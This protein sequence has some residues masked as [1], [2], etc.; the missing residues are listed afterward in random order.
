MS[1]QPIKNTNCT[2]SSQEL[3]RYSRHLSLPEIGVNGQEKLKN[4]SV[5]CIGCGGLGSP[6]LVY[7]AAAGIGRIGIIDPDLVEES[8]LQRQIIHKTESIGKAKVNS[9]RSSIKALNPFCSVETFQACLTKSNALEIIKQFDIICDCSDNFPSRYLINDSCVILEK[10]H[11]YGAISKFEGQA[12][13]FNIDQDSPNFRDLVPT[14]PP[15]NLLPSCSEAGVMGILPGIIGIIQA[16]ETIKIITGIGTSLSGRLL[17][18]NALDMKFKE[19]NLKKESNREK[20]KNLIDY[21]TFCSEKMPDFKAIN[22]SPKKL[23]DLMEKDPENTILLDVRNEEEYLINSIPGSILIP[24]VNIQN[25]DAIKRIEEL[26]KNK[27]LY[28]HCKTGQRSLEAIYILQKYGI[29][30]INIEGGINSW[31]QIKYL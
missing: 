4:S 12:S 5:L 21:E 23:N 11:I 3:K 9:A 26:S 25:G 6:L 22:I 7:L 24:L 19:L 18:F 17:V 1:I 15:M 10:P 27:I 2:L 29:K 13:V 28:I 20:I 30:A 14:P 31:N 8:N 16:T